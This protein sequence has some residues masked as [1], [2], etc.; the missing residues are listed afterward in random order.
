MVY[1]HRISALVSM[2]TLLIE[3]G[4]PPALLPKNIGLRGSLLLDPEAWINRRWS[5]S[6]ALELTRLTGDD[7]CGLHAGER[8]QSRCASPTRL[9]LAWTLL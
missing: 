5:L 6:L 1:Q 4:I 3:R 9:I 7:L 2:G 8:I